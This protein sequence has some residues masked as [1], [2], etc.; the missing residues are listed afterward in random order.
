MPVRYAMLKYAERHP[1]LDSISLTRTMAEAPYSTECIASTQ[2][3]SKIPAY[4]LSTH[5]WAGSAVCNSTLSPRFHI[6]DHNS[7]RSPL[8][9]QRTFRYPELQALKSSRGQ[10]L[11]LEAKPGSSTS[12]AMLVPRTLKPSVL[13]EATGVPGTTEA[14]PVLRTLEVMPVLR[15]PKL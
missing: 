13:P 7:G 12:E 5:L 6:P 8:H 14:T 3:P 1:S 15:A 11:I 10:Y 4:W 2:S 9:F